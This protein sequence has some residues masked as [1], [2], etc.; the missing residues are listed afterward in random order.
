[1]ILKNRPVTFRLR[2]LRTFFLQYQLQEQAN[3][4]EGK[5]DKATPESKESSG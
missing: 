1:M 3:R 5:Y 4:A 2:Y